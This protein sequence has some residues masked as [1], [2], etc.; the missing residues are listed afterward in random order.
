MNEELIETPRYRPSIYAAPFRKDGD[1]AEVE[2]LS[3]SE[4]DSLLEVS[5]L[6]SVRRHT[7]LYPEGGE[8]RFVY[9]VVSG[10]AETYQLLANGEKR[11]TAFLFPR[12]IMGLSENGTYVATAQSLTAVTAF[13]IPFDALEAILERDPSLDIGLLCKLCHEL[14]RSQ[15]HAITVSKNEAPARLAS[16]L[17]WIDHAYAPPGR[18]AGE[19]NLPMAR[20]DIADYVGLSVESVSRALQVLETQGMIRRKG[21]RFITVLDAAKLR[22]LAGQA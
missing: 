4:Q 7:V 5:Q 13:R 22:K 14:R 9:N 18:I 20:H 3:K 12:D 15:H 17:L 8:A 1:G 10:V 11:I 16:F 2:L 19:L 6:V 21:P